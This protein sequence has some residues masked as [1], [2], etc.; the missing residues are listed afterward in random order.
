MHIENDEHKNSE[1]VIRCSECGHDVRTLRSLKQKWSHRSRV[2]PRVIWIVLVSVL[3][4]YGL[5]SGGWQYSVRPMSMA[6]GS[7]NWGGQSSSLSR[8]ALDE[9]TRY[10]GLADLEVAIGGAD[11]RVVAQVEE[12]LARLDEQIREAVDRYD[13]IEAGEVKGATPEG[14]QFG[15]KE[16]RGMRVEETAYSFLG[17]WLAVGYSDRLSDISD[18]G[19]F[20]EFAHLVTPVVHWSIRPSLQYSRTLPGGYR[21]VTVT[22]SLWSILG[23]LSVCMVLTA[24]I[25]WLGRRSVVKNRARGVYRLCDWRW[26]AMVICLVLFVGAGVIALVGAKPS[27]MVISHAYQDIAMSPVYSIDELRAAMVDPEKARAIGQ[28]IV[29]LIPDLR[30]KQEEGIRAGE[31]GIGNLGNGYV[32]IPD[33]EML[34]GQLWQYESPAGAGL[35]G[36]PTIAAGGVAEN[37]SLNVSIGPWFRLL[38]WNKQV[39]PTQEAVVAYSGVDFFETWRNLSEFGMLTVRWTGRLSRT[40]ISLRP[41]SLVLLPMLLYWVWRGLHG[42]SRLLIRLKERRRERRNQCIYCAYPL[43]HEGTLARYPDPGS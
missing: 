42:T 18:P 8:T 36:S 34:V 14:V 28:V 39:Y 17:R 6:L 33:E 20:E 13:L 10:L 31:I 26:G 5:Y 1:A 27:T 15:L 41:T 11:E 24:C 37:R 32:Y 30:L 35:N 3:V 21:Q 16:A 4:G 29:D 7:M 19:A 9:D 12:T 2:I 40:R 23:V 25:R 22:L 38:G 43:S